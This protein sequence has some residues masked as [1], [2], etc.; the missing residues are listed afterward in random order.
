MSEAKERTRIEKVLAWL[1]YKGRREGWLAFI[2]M[3]LTGLGLVLYLVLH[4][5]ML[6]QLLIGETAYDAFIESAHA[7]FY[8]ALDAILIFG[9]LFHGLNGLR[10]IALGF[11]YGTRLQA[12]LFW[13]AFVLTLLLTAIAMWG[14]TTI[15]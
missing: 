1:D 13:L 6:R 12:R 5:Y 2:L 7:P 15:G 4:F 8:L 10:V 11:G 9:L 14:I 3:R